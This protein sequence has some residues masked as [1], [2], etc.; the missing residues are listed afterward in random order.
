MLFALCREPHRDGKDMWFFGL[1]LL[2]VFKTFV[3][4]C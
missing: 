4:L 1:I 2:C 3:C